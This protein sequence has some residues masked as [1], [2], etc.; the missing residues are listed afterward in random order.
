MDM[1]NAEAA[2]NLKRVTE[3]RMFFIYPICSH[4]ILLAQ[5]LYKRIT[6]DIPTKRIAT[7][8]LLS[9]IHC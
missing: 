8:Y 3:N 4:S 2:L 7:D 5:K 6:S 1:P 9:F